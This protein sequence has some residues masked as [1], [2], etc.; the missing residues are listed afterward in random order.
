MARELNIGDVH[1]PVAHPG[2]LDFCMDVGEKYGCD[3]FSFV[4]D[5]VDWHAISFHAHHPEA[6]G[7]K[8]EYELAKSKIARWYKAFP[9]AKVCIGNHDERPARL[10]ETVNIP[11]KFLRDYN[12]LWGTPGWEWVDSHVRDGVYHFHGTGTGGMHPAYNSMLKQMMSV[13][14]G[15]VH[16]AA[17]VKWRAN[18]EARFFGMDTGCGVDDKAVA[19]AYGK[20]HQV[21]SMLG[22][23]VVIDGVPYHEIMPIGQGEK[24]HRSRFEYK[25]LRPL[26]RIDD[27]ESSVAL[28]PRVVAA[29]ERLQRDQG[30]QQSGVAS[31]EVSFHNTKR[32]R[33]GARG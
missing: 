23:G 11:A 28:D 6:A 16:S 12:E 4:G 18:P 20:H 7:P 30:N 22:C 13:V 9:T 31:R 19:M 29:A 27:E 3:V 21:R 25:T 17:G 10:V 32:S 8:D 33:R 5:V 24:Y 1:E 15:H 14:Q 2:Y 26:S